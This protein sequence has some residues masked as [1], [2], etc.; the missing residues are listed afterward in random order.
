MLVDGTAAKGSERKFENAALHRTSRWPRTG[1]FECMQRAETARAAA[2]Q[3]CSRFQHAVNDLPEEKELL[4]EVCGAQPLSN[5]HSH[6]LIHMRG[7]Q[8]NRTGRDGQ[9][10]SGRGE[11]SNMFSNEHP[12]LFIHL[13]RAGKARRHEQP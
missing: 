11:C 5:Q 6:P 9:E 2:L 7:R 8:K 1:A 10:D 12:H 4:N 3:R 13:C